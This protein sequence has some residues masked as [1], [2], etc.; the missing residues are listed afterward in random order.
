MAHKI[1]WNKTKYAN[2][3]AG[4]PESKIEGL[5]SL[6]KGF[7]PRDG[8]R[9]NAFS[10]WT[11]YQKRRVRDYYNRVQR[12]EAQPKLIVRPRTEKN[13]AVLH[14]LFHQE[15]PSSQFKVAFVPYHK[16]V[17]SLPGAKQ[18]KPRIK[19][20][21]GGVEVLNG[22][23]TRV[24]Y[25]FDHKALVKDTKKEV[26]R[27]AKKMQDTSI[28]FVQVGLNQT[29]SDKDPEILSRDITKWINKYGNWREWLVGLVGYRLRKGVGK[30]KMLLA[31]K[32][33]RE[34]NKQLKNKERKALIHKKGKSY[35][36]V[37]QG[38]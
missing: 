7:E 28:Y 30:R 32:A 21:D 37:Y 5:R 11:P 31:M 36:K 17:L 18:I 29:I 19:I 22:V 12:L 14:K 15:L 2:A 13:L 26:L 1:K 38:I 9:I 20:L 34:A 25:K 8:Y 6:V 3:L 27:V 24:T 16:P 4:N 35:G 23:G 10:S 33:G